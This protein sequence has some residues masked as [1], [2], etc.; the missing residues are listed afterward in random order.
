[1]ECERAGHPGPPRGGAGPDRGRQR[2]LKP[3]LTGLP[4]LPRTSASLAW[5]SPTST[6]YLLLDLQGVL[7]AK[8]VGQLH[9]WAHLRKASSY[10]SPTQHRM[11]LS[12]L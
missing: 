3:P 10:P 1:M 5:G 8:A 4:S 12:V 2:A 7:I 9:T 6:S 11:H